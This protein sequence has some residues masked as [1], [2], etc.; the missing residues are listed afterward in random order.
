MN[1][2]FISSVTKPDSSAMLE[3]DENDPAFKAAMTITKEDLTKH[4]TILAS[5]EF[6]GRETGYPGNDLASAYIAGEIKRIGIE[7]ITGDSYFQK[8]DFKW[9]SW[10]DISITVGENR[11]KHLWDFLS[12]PDK[13][14]DLGEVDLDEVI[15]LGYGIDDPKYTDYKRAKIEGKV[16]M[17]NEGEPMDEDG[18]YIISGDTQETEWSQYPEKKL[19]LAHKMGAKAVLIITKDIQKMLGENRRK[20]LG[21]T[22]VIG[23]SEDEEA[24]V[25]N[26]IY[27]SSN[28]AKDIIGSKSKKMIKARKKMAKGKS[29]SLKLKT[30]MKLIQ[31]RKDYSLAGNNIL[32]YM[33]GTDKKDEL[34]V[35]SAHYDHVGMKGDDVYNGADDNGSGSTTVLELAEAFQKAKMAGNGP[36]RSILFLWVTG[37]EKGLLGSEYYATYP[38]FPLENTIADINID[39]VGRVDEKYKDN[40]NYIYVIGSDRISTDL[41]DANEEVNRNYSQITLDYTYNSEDDPNRFYFRSDH[42]NFAKNGIPS[43]FFFNG[44]HE[45]YHKITDTVDKINFDKMTNVARHIFYLAWKLSN[46]E[47]DL[48]ITNGKA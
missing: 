24:P 7:P 5:D 46:Q 27:I 3:V 19:E 41:H 26:S 6:Q 33:E 22:V 40:P 42:Y 17:I 1:A 11:Y 37:E 16:I 2:Q 30:D 45:D 44:V 10:D 36:R 43:I 13:N 29:K 8:V 23:Q 4:L 48:K 20:L 47:A 15:F 14:V 9:I 31:K 28:I 12:F 39:M 35:V 21:P 25:A 32:A 38:V 34:L 18:K